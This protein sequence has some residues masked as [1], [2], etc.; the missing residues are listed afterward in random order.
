MAPD[1]EFLGSGDI[2]SLAD[3]GTGYSVVEEMTWVPFSLR[4]V[5]NLAIVA[6]LPLLPLVLLVF[7]PEELFESLVH[8]LF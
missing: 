3:L 5:I 8:V 7:S 6:A 2:Q 1:E 4:A